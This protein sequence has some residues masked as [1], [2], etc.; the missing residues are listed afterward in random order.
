MF[1]NLGFYGMCKI[2]KYKALLTMDP[3]GLFKNCGYGISVLL[4][5]LL[6]VGILQIVAIL[7]ILTRD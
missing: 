7:T 6:I 3:S 4:G 1:L 5:L 2:L